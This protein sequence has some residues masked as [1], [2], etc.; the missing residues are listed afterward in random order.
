MNPVIPPELSVPL[1]QWIP[2][3][4]VW[5]ALLAGLIAALIFWPVCPRSSL[6]T[7]LALLLLGA[8]FAVGPFV[9][10]QLAQMRLAQRWSVEQFGLQS[11]A[12]NTILN[13]VRAVGF[14][15][16]WTAVFIGRR[17]RGPLPPPLPVFPASPVDP[18]PL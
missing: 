5:F 17:R 13:V 9:N 1:V 11:L 18:R 7:L 12:A 6:L 8:T 4:P 2:L 16:L 14:G 10:A 3:L 15:L